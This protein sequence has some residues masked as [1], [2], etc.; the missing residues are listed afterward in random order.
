MPTQIDTCVMTPN[1]PL[2][3]GGAISLM[4][5]GTMT[6]D[7]PAPRPAIPRPRAMTKILPEIVSTKAPMMYIRAVARMAGRRPRRDENGPEHS[8]PIKAPTVYD[9]DTVAKAASSMGMQSGKKPVG[10]SSRVAPTQFAKRWK[11]EMDFLRQV[12]TSWGALSS[13]CEGS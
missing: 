6:V 3:L 9:D 10:G 8:A 7:A 11:V 5:K 4:Y 2:S 1:M 13:A 12:M